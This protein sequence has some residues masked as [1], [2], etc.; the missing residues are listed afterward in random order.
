MITNARSLIVK[1][2]LDMSIV[3]YNQCQLT[4]VFAVMGPFSLFFV[5]IFTAYL[6][7]II[8]NGFYYSTNIFKILVF[9]LMIPFVLE[10]EKDFMNLV[11]GW[12]KYL[13]IV[14]IIYKLNI[15]K[16]EYKKQ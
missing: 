9:I 10:F 5:S 4:D 8:I 15:Y 1:K 16:F 7:S 11:I 6:F 3:D 2:Y 13:P 12:F 14:F